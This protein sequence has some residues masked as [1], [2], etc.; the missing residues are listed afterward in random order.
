MAQFRGVLQGNRGAVSRLGT[1]NSGLVSHVDGW[2][3]GTTVSI[4][5]N[6]V[7]G[8]DEVTV[9]ITSGSSPSSE[10]ELYLGT[11]ILNPTNSKEIIRK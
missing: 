8:N 9:S 5:H 10:P 1:K 4:S 2:N 3:I 11:F 7:T 6:K